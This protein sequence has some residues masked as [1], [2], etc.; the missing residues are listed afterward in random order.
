MS[1]SVTFGL[2]CLCVDGWYISQISRYL[3]HSAPELANDWPA[4]SDF[5]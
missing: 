1:V 3:Q 2:R 4:D 5:L